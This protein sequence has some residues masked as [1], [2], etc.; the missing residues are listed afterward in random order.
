MEENE[1]DAAKEALTAYLLK[2]FSVATEWATQNL[3]DITNS[4][5]T[6]DVDIETIKANFKFEPK[7]ERERE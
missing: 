1:R 6:I 3:A 7:K 5:V 4:E 2:V